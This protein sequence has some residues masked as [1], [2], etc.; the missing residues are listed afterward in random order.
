MRDM[1]YDKAPK[2]G[3][4]PDRG[5][6]VPAVVSLDAAR[7]ARRENEGATIIGFPVF[8]PGPG[9][10]CPTCTSGGAA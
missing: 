8:C 2:Q 1:N 5:D 9:C 6:R 4:C 3:G 10:M 7:K